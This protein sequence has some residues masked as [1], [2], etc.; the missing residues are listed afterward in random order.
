M[1][2]DDLS[3]HGTGEMKSKA[4]LFFA[5]L[6][7][8][9]VP[10]QAQVSITT[11][12]YDTSR[13]AANLNETIL[14]QSDV[15]VTQFGKLFSYAV[16]GSIYAQP[17]YVPNV[18]IN[19]Q[20]HNVIYVA[21]MNDVVYAFDADNNS[22]ANAAPLWSVDFRNASAAIGP[23]V[24]PTGNI[25]GNVGIESTP[26]IDL[27][28]NTIYLVTYTSEKGND[29]HRL[30]ALDIASGAE[31]FGGP[32][33]I[34]ASV[35]GS[36]YG[37]VNGT[38]TFTPSLQNQRAGLALANGMV[39]IAWASFGDT[40]NFHGWLM[41]YNAQTLQQVSALRTTP[42]GMDGGIW[43]SDAAPVVDANGNVIYMI[44]NGDYDGVSDFVGRIADGQRPRNRMRL[45][46]LD[47]GASRLDRSRDG[48][49]RSPG[50][51]RI[52]LPWPRPG[53]A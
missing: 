10:A 2:V 28:S 37:S 42:N 44:A 31:K 30:H 19:G 26:V 21:T 34:S 8:I 40:G 43:M 4:T 6:Y 27:T 3:L 51:Q 48:R 24:S 52:S 32:V 11:E 29:F 49:Q 38:L 50:L 41:S 16:D 33:A 23:V 20:T 12:S 53:P 17:L 15:N 22:G 45:L 46:R 1:S 14:N 25:S 9:G 13:T 47:L 39:M 36:G 5:L 35:P 18:T 7:V